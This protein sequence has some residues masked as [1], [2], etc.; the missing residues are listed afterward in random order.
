MP[1]EVERAPRSR[2][3]PGVEQPLGGGERE[4]WHDAPGA[5]AGVSVRTVD[6]HVRRIRV[7]LGRYQVVLT[8][9]RGHGYRFEARPDVRVLSAATRLA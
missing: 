2:R 1:V 8:S 7:K 6:T 4:F 9:V 5:A 3:S